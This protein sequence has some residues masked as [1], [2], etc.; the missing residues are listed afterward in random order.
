[1]RAALLSFLAK[2]QLALILYLNCLYTKPFILLSTFMCRRMWRW[3]FFFLHRFLCGSMKD[4]LGGQRFQ[5]GGVRWPNLESS[6]CCVGGGH[7]VPDADAINLADHSKL[8]TSSVGRGLWRHRG[9]PSPREQEEQWEEERRTS[10]Y[11]TVPFLLRP[12][13]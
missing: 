6:L 13:G 4:V 10:S 3:E 1:M 11:L 7:G 9:S 8:I 5:R 2:E 12:L